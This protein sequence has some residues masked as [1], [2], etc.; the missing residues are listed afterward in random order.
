MKT[1]LTMGSAWLALMAVPAT[2]QT[3]TPETT[4][5]TGS[6]TAAGQAPAAGYP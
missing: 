1:M 2:A 5:G 6:A 3:T 4:T